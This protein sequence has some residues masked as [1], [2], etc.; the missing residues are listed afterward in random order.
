[1]IIKLQYILIV[2]SFKRFFGGGGLCQTV[3][4]FK[5]FFCIL[6]ELQGCFEDDHNRVLESGPHSLQING[7][8]KCASHCATLGSYNYFGL[9]VTIWKNSFISYGFVC[10]FIVLHVYLLLSYW[11]C[12]FSRNQKFFF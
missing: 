2:L 1:M 12:H 10:I 11:R 8:R 9:Q 6:D 7:Q 3:E 4:D 5:N